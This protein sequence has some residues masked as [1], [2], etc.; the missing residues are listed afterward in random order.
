MRMPAGAH[1]DDVR[2][3]GHSEA[4]GHPQ[5]LQEEVQ[6]V[7]ELQQHDAAQQDTGSYQPFCMG[8]SALGVDDA[9]TALQES[10]DWMRLRSYALPGAAAPPGQTS[11]ILFPSQPSICLVAMLGTSASAVCCVCFRAGTV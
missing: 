6:H 9:I 11:H 7:L 3:R 5:S 8:P 1:A 2:Q 4:G 10:V